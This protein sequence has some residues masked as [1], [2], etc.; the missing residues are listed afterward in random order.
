MIPSNLNPISSSRTLTALA[1][2]SNPIP[3]PRQF[4]PPNLL[5]PL[6]LTH[7]GRQ[8]VKP[9][10]FTA[11]RASNPTKRSQSVSGA[12]SHNELDES[13]GGEDGL[14]RD[15]KVQVGNAV[16]PSFIPP[17]SKL[18]LNDQASFLLSFAACTAMGRAAVSL[19]KLADTA[20]EELPSTMAAV[21]LSG[22]EISDLTLELSD[23]SHE[24][25]EGVNKSAKA[26]QAAKAGIG[27]IGTLAHQHTISMIEERANLPEISLQPV[28]VGAAKKTSR[29]VGQATKSLLNMISGGERENETGVKRVE[30]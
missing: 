24:I 30:K 26:V 6:P 2:P 3:F 27:Q 8:C 25:T 5:H 1:L 14:E 12:Q 4:N 18:S 13:V 17:W 22:M 20:R 29:A 23:L 9:P 16:V 28:V 21:R 19:S 7:L 15:F 11:I 10:R